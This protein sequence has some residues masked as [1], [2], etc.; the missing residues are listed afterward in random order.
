MV[1]NTQNSQLFSMIGMLASNKEILVKSSVKSE[2]E[3]YDLEKHGHSPLGNLYIRNYSSSSFV[4]ESN[5]L[6]EEVKLYSQFIRLVEPH[7]R[8]PPFSRDDLDTRS[9]GNHDESFED[10]TFRA[11]VEGRAYKS[12]PWDLKPSYSLNC[13][14]PVMAFNTEYIPSMFNFF[15]PGPFMA[16]DNSTKSQSIESSGKCVLL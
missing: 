8:L 3:S 10:L 1:Y 13:Q 2:W 14:R 6:T 7:D 15:S 9:G 5:K 4:L 11:P 12:T 16:E